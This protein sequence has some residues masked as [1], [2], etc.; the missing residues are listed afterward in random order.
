MPLLSG[1]G[2]VSSCAS[3]SDLSGITGMSGINGYTWA[4]DV[5]PQVLDTVGSGL[6]ID[7]CVRELGA[8]FERHGV[9][10][11][12]HEDALQLIAD[13][14]PQGH[15]LNADM[16]DQLAVERYRQI[17]EIVEDFKNDD[18]QV[19]KIAERRL[20]WLG[21]AAIRPFIRCCLG[22]ETPEIQSGDTEQIVNQLIEVLRSDY[23]YI[24]AFATRYLESFG[25]EAVEPLI[26]RLDLEHFDQLRKVAWI[27]EEIGDLRA[28]IPLIKVWIDVWDEMHRRGWE[29]SSPTLGISDAIKKIIEKNLNDPGVSELVPIL[30]EAGR[31]DHI[32]VIQPLVSIFAKLRDPRTIP[33][34]IRHI[35]LPGVWEIL[36]DMGDEAILPAIDALD[37]H[38]YQANQILRTI[39]RDTVDLLIDALGN[40][41][42][43]IRRG[44]AG[45]LRDIVDPRAAAPERATDVA[46]ALA[47]EIALEEDEETQGVLIS[48][49][50]QIVIAHQDRPVIET[51][52][53]EASRAVPSIIERLKD[54]KDVGSTA[55]LLG[56]LRDV[57][58]FPVL[59]QSVIVKAKRDE[60]ERRKSAAHVSFNHSL[61]ALESIVEGIDVRDRCVFQA[62][63]YLIKALE[64]KSARVRCRVVRLLGKIGREGDID[65]VVSN[66]ARVI[67][68]DDD[69]DVLRAAR[70]EIVGIGNPAVAHL[71]TVPRDTGDFVLVKDT[72]GMILDECKTDAE[73]RVF[74]AQMKAGLEKFNMD[75]EAEVEELNASIATVE[76]RL[77]YL[78]RG[79]EILE[80][81]LWHLNGLEALVRV[82][83]TLTFWDRPTICYLPVLEQNQ[84]A[85]DELISETQWYREQIEQKREMM[86]TVG[87][88]AEHF[89]E[90]GMIARGVALSPDYFIARL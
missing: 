9:S 47:L 68:S 28:V 69:M 85:I 26:S 60:V 58:A 40:S 80:R 81:H 33:F 32:W 50:H 45:T 78:E 11:R 21:E 18:L 59:A 54:G 30:I 37:N 42:P 39:G 83:I 35:G 55:T 6:P 14:A 66:L 82:F 34:L 15:T 84:A 51:I 61:Y 20:R 38:Y 17:A 41:D 5:V 89:T 74:A 56:R 1:L 25:K 43:G 3:V 79:Q 49:L 23:C 4:D 73:R 22:G 2:A 44:A 75:V 67:V 12:Y 70:E 48:A 57:R 16:L 46:K 72:L 7:A 65:R 90:S 88:M 24:D 63:P 31:I 86:K 27:L 64:C 76:S 52:G 62:V 29:C 77:P 8:F 19:R 13:E 87:E 36:A 53:E 71:I 10:G